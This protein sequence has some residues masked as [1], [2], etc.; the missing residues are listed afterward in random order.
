[1]PLLIRPT[2]F[3]DTGTTY[4]YQVRDKEPEGI[5][6]HD[7]CHVSFTSN[8]L[9]KTNSSMLTEEK[10]T[11]TQDNASYTDDIFGSS[12]SPGLGSTPSR[13]PSDNHST[14]D[15]QTN[16][17]KITRQDVELTVDLE[18]FFNASEA[19]H[20]QVNKRSIETRQHEVEGKENNKQRRELMQK[21]VGAYLKKT[22]DVMNVAHSKKIIRRDFPTSLKCYPIVEVDVIVSGIDDFTNENMTD[23]SGYALSGNDADYSKARLM[24]IRM[25]N[26]IPL[27]DGAEATACGVVRCLQHTTLWNSFGLEISPITTQMLPGVIDQPCRSIP[28]TLNVPTFALSDSVHVAPFFTKNSAHC[29]YDEDEHSHA[30]DC[31]SSSSSDDNAVRYTSNKRRKIPSSFET[32]LKPAGLRLGNILVVVH[33]NAHSSQ[34][35]LPTLSKGRLPMNDKAI[36]IALHS[37]L[38][39][40]LRSLQKSNPKLF[41][42]PSQLKKTE[43]DII[44]VS[45]FASA[46]SSMILNS[47]SVQT[48]TKCLST[49]GISNVHEVNA[50]RKKEGDRQT[51]ITS[52]IEAFIR[53]SLKLYDEDR[54]KEASVKRVVSNMKKQVA[55][56]KQE[57]MAEIH[58]DNGGDSGS[59]CTVNCNFD[60]FLDETETVNQF[61][62]LDFGG[63]SVMST[64]TTYEEDEMKSIFSESYT[65]T[66]SS[67]ELETASLSSKSLEYDHW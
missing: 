39:D 52:F 13:V 16:P 21:A 61:E 7:Y 26:G 22:I 44:F 66:A 20:V 28:E 42:A 2:S 18:D 29:L 47:N 4:Q 48:Q 56:K 62:N 65:H 45:S 55:T 54:K 8:C 50:E 27:L 10:K 12:D 11:A 43:R 64:V 36:N 63:R 35:P 32:T 53:R 30:S 59:I 23:C 58:N 67:Q 25:V 15:Q 31:E 9:N 33:L 1:M 24:L 38:T 60:Q 14:C 49:M 51:E 40:C 46:L 37:G 34:L 41:L 3:K 5:S 57:S 17:S 19:S 6:N